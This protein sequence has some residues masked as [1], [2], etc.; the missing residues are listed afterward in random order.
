MQ[1]ILN[2]KQIKAK[3]KFLQIC[4]FCYVTRERYFSKFGFPRLENEDIRLVSVVDPSAH[5]QGIQL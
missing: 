3:T 2:K 5:L 4:Q 1:I